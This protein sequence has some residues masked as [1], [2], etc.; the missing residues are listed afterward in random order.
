MVFTRPIRRAI[1]GATRNEAADSTPAQKNTCPTSATEASK[2]WNSQSATSD[3]TAN[4]LPKE[5]SVN[6][7]AMRRTIGRDSTSGALGAWPGGSTEG[8]SRRY[9]MNTTMPSAP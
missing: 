4:P 6:T 2:R 8:V 1:Q 3:C 7:A 9:T 5:S